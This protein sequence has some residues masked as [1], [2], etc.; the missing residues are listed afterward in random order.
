MLV[1]FTYIIITEI[2]VDVYFG[3]RGR[4]FPFLI[5]CVH[6]EFVVIAY[7]N[8]TV[9]YVRLYPFNSIYVFL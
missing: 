8:T 5:S 2:Y 9:Y 7:V 1:S 3:G 4:E 6:S